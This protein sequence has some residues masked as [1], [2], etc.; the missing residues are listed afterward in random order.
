[1]KPSIIIP[2]L[3]AALTLTSTPSFAAQPH[4]LKLLTPAKT[5]I[6]DNFAKPALKNRRLTRGEW[7]LDKNT[8]SCTQDDALYKSLKNHGPALWYDIN[9]HNAIIQFD[10]KASKTTE[11]VVFTVNSKEGHVFRFVTGQKT[12]V[13]A[14]KPDHTSQPLVN[15][16]PPLTRQKWVPVTVEIAGPK[17]TLQI[18][19]YSTTVESPTYDVPKIIV[20]FSHHFGTLNL[21][22]F[23]VSEGT[24]IK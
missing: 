8:A 5:L 12:D 13:R 20:G 7:T 21:R 19:D 3:L 17:A 6:N 2:L 23:R 22:N 16:G 15:D 9:Y 1:M 11:K 10:F 18:G 24:P 4:K 14:W